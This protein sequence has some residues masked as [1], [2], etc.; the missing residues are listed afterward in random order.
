MPVAAMQARTAGSTTCCQSCS[1]LPASLLR[2]AA[3]PACATMKRPFAASMWPR[4]LQRPVVPE[5]IS[6]GK[7]REM[8]CPTQPPS[9][10]AAQLDTES[11]VPTAP[12]VR[13]QMNSVA[14]AAEHRHALVCVASFQTRTLSIVTDRLT[15]ASCLWRACEKNSQQ[16][17][18]YVED[19]RLNHLCL[20][21][22]RCCCHLQHVLRRLTAPHTSVAPRQRSHVAA[23]APAPLDTVA[24]GVLP[25]AWYASTHHAHADHSGDRHRCLM[26][27]HHCLL[28]LHFAL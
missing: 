11:P 23:A 1:K 8:S 28:L 25:A 6:A 4:K 14:R 13:A 15:F 27:K 22:C 21:H 18:R 19:D 2:G 5:R 7:G 20:I 10:Q 3:Q 17:S 16:H 26:L 24:S 9:G 12:L